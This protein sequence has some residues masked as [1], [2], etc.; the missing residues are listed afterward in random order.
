MTGNTDCVA[1]GRAM[2]TFAEQNV[3]TLRRQ[4]AQ[5]EKQAAYLAELLRG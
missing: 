2:L 3:E 5:A 1:L 4:L